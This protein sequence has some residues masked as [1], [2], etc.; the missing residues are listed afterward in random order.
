MIETRMSA[1]MYFTIKLNSKLLH[2]AVGNC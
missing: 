2:L 1:E